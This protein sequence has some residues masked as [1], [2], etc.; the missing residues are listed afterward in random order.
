[1]SAQWTGGSFRPT[2]HFLPA[3]FPHHIMI[4]IGGA[5]FSSGSAK[6]ACCCLTIYCLF[7]FDNYCIVYGSF[8]DVFPMILCG[9]FVVVWWALRVVKSWMIVKRWG[10]LE[11]KVIKTYM[12]TQKCQGQILPFLSEIVRKQLLFW[13]FN[14]V[15]IFT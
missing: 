3:P 9:D 5:H 14:F 7:Y 12:G 1:M 13:A 8:R 10:F 15:Q 6:S 4:E 2:D 11:F